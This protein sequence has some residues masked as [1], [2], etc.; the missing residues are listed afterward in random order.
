M[1][2]LVKLI[3]VHRLNGASEIVVE[4]RLEGENPETPPAKSSLLFLLLH[5]FD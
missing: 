4:T 3:C 1:A 2:F 5:M